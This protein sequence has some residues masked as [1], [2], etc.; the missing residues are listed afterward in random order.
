MK[1]YLVGGAVRDKLLGLAVK[2]R[3][4][5]VV[6]VTVNDMLKMGFKQV[7]K[8]FPVFLHPKTNEEYALARVE[9]KV[10]PGYTG[11][12]F[13][14]TPEVTLEDDLKRR[15]LTINAM[16][17]DEEGNLID[18]YGGL[19]DL[20][21]KTL[22]HVSPAFSEDPVRILRV[23][24]FYARF[25]HLGFHIADETMDLMKKMVELGE[26]NALVAERVW[27]ELERALIE[28][29]PEGFFSVLHDCN[30][31]PIL[32]PHL[33]LNGNGMRAL[34]AAKTLSPMSIVR[35]AALLHDQN[36]DFISAI[37]RR[38]R[39]PNSYKELARLVAMYY[40]FAIKTH[41]A[42]PDDLMTL[43]S[44]VDVFRRYD[45]FILFLYAVAAIAAVHQVRFHLKWLAACADVTRKVDVK[46][47]LE[48]GLNGQ[49]LANKLR[50]LRTMA[51]KDWL[52]QA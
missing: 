14:T 16:A 6:G 21:H 45:R 41:Q 31:L 36:K 32:F 51:I 8:D 48:Q 49:A 20:Q 4:Y 2:E 17:E 28:K 47:L 38:Y 27:K 33:T 13:D 15:D 25:K 18:P 23:G 29:D 40:P 5:V 11:F 42:T 46:P 22:R 9:R 34:I 35:F 52:H 7:G 37:S 44:A 24:R 10:K 19:K 26:V 1:I 30:A 43:F 3:D 50:E 12:T 39:V